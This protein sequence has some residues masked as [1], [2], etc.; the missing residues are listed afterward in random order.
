MSK[1]K[2]HLPYDKTVVTELKVQLADVL[3]RTVLL[4]SS[5]AAP[6][7]TDS[8][9]NHGDI[10]I[11]KDKPF[12]IPATKSILV[13]SSLEDFHLDIQGDVTSIN[14]VCRGLFI[15]NGETGQVVVTV[16][17]GVERIRLQYIWS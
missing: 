4:K 17:D 13:L 15:N 12:T 5:V 11:T 10:T 14:V 7:P 16:P 1:S 2:K 9:F 3:T 6:I 8:V